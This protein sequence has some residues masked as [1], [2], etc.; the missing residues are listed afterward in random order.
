M[1]KFLSKKL[2][3]EK[4]FTLVELLAV[5]VILAILAAIA[6]PAIGSIIAKSKQDS[7]DASAQQMI[8]AARLAEAAGDLKRGGSISLDTLVED[9]Y[10]KRPVNPDTDEAIDNGN[11]KLSTDGEF[12]ATIDGGSGEYKAT[13]SETKA[14]E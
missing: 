10:L 8:E 6:I 11:V 9:G 5:I 7:I 1:K 2:K 14:S 13:G 12:T 3:S 4:G